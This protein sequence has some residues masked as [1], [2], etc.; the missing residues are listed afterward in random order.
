M[1]TWAKGT[2]GVW[3]YSGSGR[4]VVIAD[5]ELPSTSLLRLQVRQPA[6]N[7]KALV[8]ASPNGKYGFECGIEGSNAVIRTVTHGTP[9]TGSTAGSNVNETAAHGLTAG[10]PFTLD[11]QYED[12]VIKLTLN[13]AASPTVEWD[14]STGLIYADQDRFGFVGTVAGSKVLRA[15]V[16]ELEPVKVDNAEVLV[17]VAG[18]Q[19]WAAESESQIGKVADG[20][21]AQT[22]T[23]QA[24]VH[25]Q[26]V[27]IAGR[28]NA[29][30]YNPVTGAVT[31]WVPTSGSLPGQG[32]TPGTTT[33]TLVG[34]FYD[35]VVLND[36]ENPQ[37]LFFS[38]VG[39]P[40]DY[41]T[42]DD[43]AGS[44]YALN[45]G[46]FGVVGEPVV[47]IEQVTD[48]T[49]IVG[50][51]S[52]IWRISGD[53]ALGEPDR[54]PLLTDV[55]ALSAE[56]MTLAAD[57]L[58]LAMTTAGLYALTASGTARALSNGVLTAIVQE[59]P[60]NAT[61]SVIRDPSRHGTVLYLTASS[62]SSTHLW[63]DERIAGFSAGGGGYFPESYPDSIGPTAVGLWRG[64]VVLGGRDGYLYVYDDAQ[65]TDNGAD[66][67]SSTSLSLVTDELLT[68]DAVVSDGLLRMGLDSAS[69]SMTVWGGRTAE[70]AFVGPNRWI[71]YK[72]TSIGPNTPLSRIARAA[73]LVAELSSASGRWEIEQI[74]F[75]RSSAPLSRRR[76]VS[77]PEVAGPCPSPT[78]SEPTTTVPPGTGPGPGSGGGEPDVFVPA[79]Q[80]AFSTNA[81]GVPGGASVVTDIGDDTSTLAGGVEM[82]VLVTGD[83]GGAGGGASDTP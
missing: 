19:L 41:N 73:A 79:Q 32:S 16:C 30:I 65:K 70:E 72:Q 63:Y 68:Q 40:L 54:S 13:G 48:S 18:G 44:A 59:V 21:T 51:T 81:P 77:A 80:Y 7:V 60:D 53:P 4:T 64:K 24:A 5:G 34:S 22:G 27:Y 75:Y 82:V 50:C 33:A 62:G 38:A 55:G 1:G 9:F 57:G 23:I 45:L 14:N 8:L 69:V 37:N 74:E 78:V 25:Q 61:V 31:N 58:L 28:P 17:V 15:E 52:S 6:D 83:W 20:V 42:G 67:A 2:D 71:V 26:K 46:L 56:C 49:L 12:S 76:R 3:T 39:D 10:Q 43:L 66:I 35:R 11:A 36:R 47:C 29:R